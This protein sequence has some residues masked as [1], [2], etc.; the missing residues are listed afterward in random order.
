MTDPTLVPEQPSWHPPQNGDGPGV[1]WSQ[2]AKHSPDGLDT[3]GFNYFKNGEA[4]YYSRNAKGNKL[5]IDK[6]TGQQVELH[7]TDEELL[8]VLTG[9]MVVQAAVDKE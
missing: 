7:F 8:D 6:A 5:V 1:W 2:E 9:F 3:K 4:L